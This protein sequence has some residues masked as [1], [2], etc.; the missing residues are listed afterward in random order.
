L[1]GFKTVGAAHTRKLLKKLDQNFDENRVYAVLGIYTVG[2]QIFGV[3]L[4]YITIKI[5]L[6]NN[7]I[8]NYI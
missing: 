2:A 1:A 3:S 7:I 6:D 8:G 5:V 4:L